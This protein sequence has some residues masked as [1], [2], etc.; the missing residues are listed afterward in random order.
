MKD[1]NVFITGGAGFIGRAVVAHTLAQG[2]HVTVYDNLC[3]GS[4]EN[5]E[6]LLDQITFV[7]ADI[8]DEPTL[9]AALEDAQPDVVFHLAAHHFIPYCNKHPQETL[10]VNVTGTETVLRLA[11]QAGAQVAVVASSG[12]V[13]PSVDTPLGEDLTPAPPDVYGVSKLL[14]EHVCAYIAETTPMRCVA[15]R[16]FNTYGPYETNP[17]LIPHI[18][19]SL[20]EGPSIELGNI[21]TFRDYIY[22]EDVARLL[23]ACAQSDANF[24]VTNVGT[25]LEYTAEEIVRTFEKI[26]EMPIEIRQDPTR[27]RAVDKLHQRAS[28]AQLQALTGTQAAIGLHEGLE[29]LVEHEGLRL[30][31]A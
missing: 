24:A 19:D 5:L 25:G 29:K 18:V 8:L 15:A 28:T 1:R 27:I 22:V 20:R 4:L 7:E 26:L 21:H 11:A 12:A 9:T 23:V 16:L 6:G 3:A 10:N 13:Y 14:T 30:Q 2:A 17:H 31:R